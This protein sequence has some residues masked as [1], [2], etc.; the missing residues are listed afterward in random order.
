[1]SFG[2]MRSRVSSQRVCGSP[3][4]TEKVKL[5]MSRMGQMR[6]L[7]LDVHR[8]IVAMRRLHVQCG[9]VDGDAVEARVH[10]VPGIGGTVASSAGMPRKSA[11]MRMCTIGRLLLRRRCLCGCSRPMEVRPAAV[12]TPGIATIVARSSAG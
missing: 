5:S 11:G 10:V 6:I 1:M 2:R 4:L 3:G 8:H 7:H 12:D 9:Q